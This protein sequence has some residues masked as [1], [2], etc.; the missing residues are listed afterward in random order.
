MFIS[1]VKS[2]WGRRRLELLYPPREPRGWQGNPVAPLLLS[3]PSGPHAPNPLAT[4][5][6]QTL[7]QMQMHRVLRE[8]YSA[9]SLGLRG[10]MAPGARARG[11]EVATSRPRSFHVAA[12]ALAKDGAWGI[13][14]RAG[15]GA[16]ACDVPPRLAEGRLDAADVDGPVGSSRAPAGDDSRHSYG[17]WGTPGRVGDPGPSSHAPGSL[18][19]HHSGI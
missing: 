18:S 8:M 7:S 1:I 11:C 16:R 15:R 6:L 10:P 9:L 13:G 17:A 5:A 14:A 3:S 4:L 12:A 2:A 19:S